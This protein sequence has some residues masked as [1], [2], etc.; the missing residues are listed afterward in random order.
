MTMNK[1]AGL[2]L[3]PCFIG[4]SSLSENTFPCL[5]LPRWQQR[6]NDYKTQMPPDVTDC[7][8]VFVLYPCPMSLCFNFQPLY[9]SADLDKIE[10][11]QKEILLNEEI[12]A[13]NQDK[14]GIMGKQKFKDNRGQQ[15]WMKPLSNNCSSVAIMS[16][17]QDIPIMM[18]FK[19][20]DVRS[21]LIPPPAQKII[22]NKFVSRRRYVVFAHFQR[23]L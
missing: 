21:W 18:G 6:L 12:I 20:A 9:I 13:V 10:E 16:T 7:P 3:S 11:W 1:P 22:K 4:E 5:T 8:F 15:T 2:N 19:L 17:R 23:F 14:L